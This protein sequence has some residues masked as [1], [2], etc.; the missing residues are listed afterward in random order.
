MII[1]PVLVASYNYKWMLVT[2]IYPKDSGLSTAYPKFFEGEIFADFEV[3]DQSQKF[4]SRNICPTLQ[5][6]TVLLQSTKISSMKLLN[7]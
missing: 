7:S 1:L 2:A 3:F 5:F 6:N 4:Y